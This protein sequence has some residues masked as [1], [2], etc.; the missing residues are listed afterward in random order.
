MTT[1]KLVGVAVLCGVFTGIRG[2]LFSVAMWRLNVRIR[3]TLFNSLLT[4]EI[5]FFDTQQTGGLVHG[6]HNQTCIAYT[7]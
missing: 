3:T 5:G 6:K 1:L 4:Q 2:G 7:S